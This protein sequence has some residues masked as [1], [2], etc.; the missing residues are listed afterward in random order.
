MDTSS[1][2]PNRATARVGISRAVTTSNG[3]TG[4][5]TMDSSAPTS[6]API[7]NRAKAPTRRALRTI[8][9]NR[10]TSPATTITARV[11]INPARTVGI[12]RATN[13]VATTT[14][15]RVGI[16]PARTVMAKIT[17]ARVATNSVRTMTA[18]AGISK[19]DRR[20]DTSP[21]KVDTT[22]REDINPARV[23]TRRAR[24][25]TDIIITGEVT[26]N[27]PTGIT[28]K[29]ATTARV[30]SNAATTTTA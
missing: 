6:S 28:A 1:A 30:D 24:T 4:R 16:N 26:N 3:P 2:E 8:Q 9:N 25:T 13:P 10:A 29:G 15:A 7:T 14:T 22:P 12:N 20:R 18:R 11:G 19:I 5:T 21:V 27:A 23:A 17:M